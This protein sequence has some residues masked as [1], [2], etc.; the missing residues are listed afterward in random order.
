MCYETSL[1]PGQG[2]Q[3]G[4]LAHTKQQAIKSPQNKMFHLYDPPKIVE[5][6]H[7]FGLCVCPPTI[8]EGH[9][10]LVCVSVHLFVCLSRFRL[11]FLVKV[12]LD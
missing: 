2:L 7:V 1:H 12:V 4:A 5:G 9:Y 8:V 6:H 10:V 11:K 3:L